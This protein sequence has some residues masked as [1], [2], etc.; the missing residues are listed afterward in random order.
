MAV[1]LLKATYMEGDISV[2]APV[3]MREGLL[4]VKDPPR[5]L[6]PT[7]ELFSTLRSEEIALNCKDGLGGY[8]N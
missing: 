4:A 6:S 3:L 8:G 5:L 1:M 2:N 7:C